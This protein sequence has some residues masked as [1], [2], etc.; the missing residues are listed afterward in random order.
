MLANMRSNKSR[1][2]ITPLSVIPEHRDELSSLG[3]KQNDD[4]ML[5]SDAGFSSGRMS[6]TA[7]RNNELELH[8]FD[9]SRPM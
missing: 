1:M 5:S 7:K 2:T 6:P 8:G 4:S 9:F 3:S